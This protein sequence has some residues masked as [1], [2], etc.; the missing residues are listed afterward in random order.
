MTV[1]TNQTADADA[2]VW[3]LDPPTNFS[4]TRSTD[5][6]F[7]S[8]EAPVSVGSLDEF[9]SYNV[10]LDSFV[11]ASTT[12]LNFRTRIPSGDNGHM[13]WLT[14]TYDGGVS[15]S[16]DTIEVTLLDADDPTTIPTVFALAPAYPNPFNPTTALEVS[17]PQNTQL[18][19]RVFD[20]M[21]REVETIASGSYQAGVHHF[22]WNAAGYATGVYFARLESPLG[23]QMQK[24]LLL[25]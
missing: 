5:S 11:L 6:L 14:A 13:Y 19:L 21:G 18:A 7:L 9:Q 2:E 23:T 17:L 1:V 22:N 4:F 12:E 10:H 16:T 3:R 8:W 25:K 24:L 15:T 20:I